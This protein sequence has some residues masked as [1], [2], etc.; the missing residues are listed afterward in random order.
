MSTRAT[1][2]APLDYDDIKALA[3]KLGRPAST[4]I[5][6]SPNNDPFYCGP[7]RQALANW[8]ATEIWPLLDPEADGVHVRRVHYLVVNQR[9]RPEKLDGT[10]YENTFD[11]WQELCAA[12]LA[13]RE[14]GLVDADRF[15]DRRAGDPTFIF[16]PDDEGSEAEVVVTDD[17]IERPVLEPAP[18]YTP[19]TYAFP[20]LPTLT[21]FGPEIVEPYV[22]EVWAEKSTMNDIL[23]PLARRLGVTLV[24]GLGELSHTHCNLLVKRVLEHQRKC[25]ILYIAD[26]DPAGDGMPV[27]IA[28]KIEHILRRD[29]HDDLDIRL[30]PLVLTAEQV[31]QY[32]LPRIP[33]KDSDRRKGH[34]EARHGEGAVELD[35]LE[36]IH[37]GELARIVEDAVEVYREPTRATRQE[38]ERSADE[39]E[40]LA[41]HIR[42]EVLEQHAPALT[43]LTV[44]FARM[45]ETIR[46]HQDALRALVRDYESRIAGHVEAINGQVAEFY[47]QAELVISDIAAD[48]E[49]HKPDPDDIEWPDD[50]VADESDDQLYQSERDYL[51]QIARYKRHQGKPL[52]RRRRGGTP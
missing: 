50:Y 44:E 21:V 4:L 9:L 23:V 16:L 47:D 42:E 10:S 45:Q 8:F 18:Q 1:H 19:Q 17:S 31:A 12:S 24:T 28:R 25:R 34:F 46:P 30:D 7:T 27:S 37:P 14:L 5:V 39:L 13:A 40:R 29:G 11:D 51:A 3:Q 36:A 33:I 48:L 22:I 38:I 20:Q 32:D 52:E 43:Q 15:V 41:I 6:L 2:K 49:D 35:A 26:H